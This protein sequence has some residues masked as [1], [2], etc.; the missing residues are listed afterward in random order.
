MFQLFFLL[1]GN[2]AFQYEGTGGKEG[3]R[4]VVKEKFRLMC[5]MAVCP[6]S[7]GRAPFCRSATEQAVD[8]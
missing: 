2:R 6:C 3:V 1:P 4:Q 7:A 5:A 8:V